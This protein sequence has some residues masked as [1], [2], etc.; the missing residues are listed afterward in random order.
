LFWQ[1][2]CR[3][4]RSALPWQ[5]MGSHT[6]T[7][8]RQARL[9]GEGSEYLRLGR[10]PWLHSFLSNPKDWYVISPQVSME[11]PQAY[12]ITRLRASTCGLMIYKA[13]RF[14]DIHAFGVI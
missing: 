11:S 9:P 8:V 12:G 13:F 7:E 3:F 6:P 1:L 4:E 14:D 10:I 5:S 2:N